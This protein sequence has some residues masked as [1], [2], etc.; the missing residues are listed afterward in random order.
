MVRVVRVGDLYVIPTKTRRLSG[1]FVHHCE[2]C[3]CFVLVFFPLCNGVSFPIQP[4]GSIVWL[5]AMTT[6]RALLRSLYP[7]DPSSCVIS[8]A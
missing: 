2:L 3:G 8:S 1:V 7:A 4:S 5:G 6:T